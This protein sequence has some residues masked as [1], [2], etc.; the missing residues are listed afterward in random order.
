M[1]VLIIDDNVDR[2][3]KIINALTASP[4]SLGRQDIVEKRTAQDAREFLTTNRVD[5]LLLDILLPRRAEDEPSIETSKDLLTELSETDGLMRPGK[6]V[7]LTAYADVVAEAAKSFAER[8]WTVIETDDFSGAWIEQIG[9]CVEYIRRQG[10]QRE[11]ES[12]GVDIAILTALRD[13]E[14]A[15]IK[16]LPWSWGPDKPLDDAVFISE[17]S[18]VSEGR[19]L[20][21]VSAVADRMGMVS[22]AVLAS[23]IFAKLR[24]KVCIMPGICAAIRGRALIGDVILADTCWDYQSGKYYVDEDRVPGFS[25]DSHFINTSRSVTA[26]FEQLALDSQLLFK[27]WNDH[28]TKSDN[29]PKLLRGPVA[30]G[31]AVLADKNVSN[32][33]VE[34]QRKVR[35]IDMEIYGMYCAGEQFFP[36]PLI[37]GMKSVCDFADEEKLDKYQ[38]YAAHVSAQVVH[39]FVTRFGNELILSQQR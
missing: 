22:S 9:N 39:E 12:Y 31:S 1:K 33:I 13:P 32:R 38:A 2:I 27:I 34:Q 7:G 30:S 8:T 35:G 5:L 21:V 28:P 29:P 19:N 36:S 10:T 20:S 24:P 23:K 17:G 15:A 11:R 4:H 6:V 25:V 16:K 37:I 26:K 3:R 14:M 18:V